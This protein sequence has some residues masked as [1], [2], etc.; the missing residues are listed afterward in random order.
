[1]KL[2]LI[3]LITQ[4][5]EDTI[6]LAVAPSRTIRHLEN[7]GARRTDATKVLLEEKIMACNQQGE[8]RDCSTPRNPDRRNDYGTPRNYD[9]AFR[10]NREDRP[11]YVPRSR[12]PND[13]NNGSGRPQEA[14]Y[15]QN[16]GG[17]FRPQPPYQ[18]PQMPLNYQRARPDQEAS[19]TRSMNS[20]GAVSQPENAAKPVLNILKRVE[21]SKLP[22]A[23]VN[24]TQRMT[25]LQ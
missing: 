6:C 23:G 13:G 5:G 16:N 25:L 4:E 9:G 14:Q 15:P 2:G 18:T 1:M 17:N 24:A 10:D 12:Y 11:E 7:H 21:D 8:I 19:Q 22:L 20:Q 3:T